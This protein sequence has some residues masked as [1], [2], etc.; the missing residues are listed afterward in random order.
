MADKKPIP[1]SSA[2]RSYQESRNPAADA[3]RP[4][5]AGQED[6]ASRLTVAQVVAA[7][8][9]NVDRWYA[10]EI[11]NEQFRA[12]QRRLWDYAHGRSRRFEDSVAGIVSKGRAVPALAGAAL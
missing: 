4:V 10:D 2:G 8:R 12:E 9:R 7:I 3:A 5:G 6:G 11:T 1:D